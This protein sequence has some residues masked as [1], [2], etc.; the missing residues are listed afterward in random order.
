MRLIRFLAFL[1]LVLPTMNGCVHRAR[2][3]NTARVDPLSLTLT[4]SPNVGFAPLNVLASIRVVDERRVLVCPQFNIA[5]GVTDEPAE[6]SGFPGDSCWEDGPRVHSPRP[7]ILS[8]R[9]P[10]EYLIVASMADSGVS[11]SDR[12]TVSVHGRTE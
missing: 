1:L 12:A 8:L 5:W 9:Y 2:V 7:R 6:S 3:T 11:L 10:G 4:V